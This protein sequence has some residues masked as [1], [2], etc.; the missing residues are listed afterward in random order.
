M[1]LISSLKTQ[2]SEVRLIA[3]KSL[4]NV[5]KARTDSYT[6]LLLVVYPRAISVYNCNSICLL[7]LHVKI[8]AKS[9]L[10]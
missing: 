8:K 7:D 2:L 4:N 10:P 1:L 5:A 9:R 6:V 3:S